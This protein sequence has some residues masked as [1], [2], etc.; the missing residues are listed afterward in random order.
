MTQV[1]DLGPLVE[2][3]RSNKGQSVNV[4]T[5]A[6]VTGTSGAN[7]LVQFDGEGS[8]STKQYRRLVG[9]SQTIGNRVVMLRVGSTWV[10]LG[11][12]A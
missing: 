8:A 7:I 6:T 2:A 9:S 3:I 10:S 4:V 12:L 5:L 1:P 11:A